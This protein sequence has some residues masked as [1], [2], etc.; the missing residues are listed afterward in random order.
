[1]SCW[2]WPARVLWT[3]GQDAVRLAIV[4]NDPIGAVMRL[5]PIALAVSE[6]CES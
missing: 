2:C 3:D 1:M 4:H 6:I 5:Y